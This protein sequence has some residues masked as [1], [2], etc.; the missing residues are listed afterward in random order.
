MHLPAGGRPVIL[1]SP[2]FPIGLADEAYEERCLH[3]AEGDRL[4]LYSDG[5]PDAMNRVGE[6]FGDARLLEAIG[7]RRGESLGDGI[8]DLLGEIANWRAGERVQDDTSI[9]AVELEA[10][11]KPDDSDSRALTRSDEVPRRVEPALR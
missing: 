8:A 1:D 3:L 10:V 6:R 2:G 9:L 11:R 4:Y 7:R 5:L